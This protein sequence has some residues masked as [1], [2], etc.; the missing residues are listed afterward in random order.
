MS[1]KINSN[2]AALSA[3]RYLSVAQRETTHALRAL[4]S[5]SRIVTAGDDAAGF[6]IGEG[7]RGQISGLRQARYNA[8]NA[9]SLVQTAEGGLNEQNNILIRLR[10]LAVYS[11]SDTVSDTER[12][13]LDF[14]FQQLVSELDRISK[15]TRFGSK[16]LLSGSGEEFEFQI[17]AFSGEENIVRFRLDADTS[18]DEL[19]VSSIAIEDQDEA[20]D[21]LEDID[22]ALTQIAGNRATFGAIQSRFQYAIDNTQIQEENISNARS[23]IVDADVAEESA[24]LVRGKIMQEVGV[25][26]LASANSM[27]S[28]ALK[29]IG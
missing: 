11:A 2:T 28:Q 20:R 10:E 4:S 18:A 15:S 22:D 21:A 6:A 14:E 9:L 16:T 23:Q 25:S 19:G 27:P 3:Q 5:G 7:L 12:E 13:F 17:G 24:R 1:F 8:Q 26:V 29:L